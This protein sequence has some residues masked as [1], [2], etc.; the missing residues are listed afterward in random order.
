M[1]INDIVKLEDEI[2][3]IQQDKCYKC[4]RYITGSSCSKTCKHAERIDQIED[5]L[6]DAGEL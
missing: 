5:I 6:E 1:N 3:S 4:Q 2:L